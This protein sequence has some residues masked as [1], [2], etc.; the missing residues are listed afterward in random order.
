MSTV[1]NYRLSHQTIADLEKLS[2]LLGKSRSQIIRDLVES[3][4][5]SK[6][7]TP[8]R[9]VRVHRSYYLDTP[10]IE[11]ITKLSKRVKVSQGELLDLLV[12]NKMQELLGV[13]K[14]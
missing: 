13:R 12:E 1:P 6:M 4:D 3:C 5:P 2:S 10:T 7:E 9:Y 11:R 8:Q 14:T